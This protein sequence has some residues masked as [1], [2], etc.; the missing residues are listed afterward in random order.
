MSYISFD[1]F[2]RRA[3]KDGIENHRTREWIQKGPLT[4][5]LRFAEHAVRGQRTPTL[6]LANVTVDEEQ[7][8]RGVF[9]AFLVELESVADRLE[10]TLYVENVMVTH[11][12]EWLSRRGYLLHYTSGPST[13]MQHPCLY[14]PPMDRALRKALDFPHVYGNLPGNAA[15]VPLRNHPQPLRHKAVDPH[16]PAEE[17]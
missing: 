3:H 1:E 13:G 11:L 8:R 17:T 10:R 15:D 5:Y 16:P 12:A 7:Q 6:D 4:A 9:H 2:L 14:R